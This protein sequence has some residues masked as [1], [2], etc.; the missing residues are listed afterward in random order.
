M[1]GI[2]ASSQLHAGSRFTPGGQSAETIRPVPQPAS[3][4]QQSN[5][6]EAQPLETSQFVAGLSVLFRAR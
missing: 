1:S 6:R 3:Q 4:N 5:N 2:G